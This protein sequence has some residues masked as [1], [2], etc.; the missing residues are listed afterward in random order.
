VQQQVRGRGLTL[1]PQRARRPHSGLIAI[2]ILVIL[3]LI[4]AGTGWWF[5]AGRWTEAPSLLKLSQQQATAK[6]AEQGLEVKLGQAR[7]S[8]VVPQGQVILQDPAPND[9]VR[10]GGVITLILS[11]GPERI[12]VPGVAGLQQSEAEAALTEKNLKFTVKPTFDPSVVNGTAVGTEPKEGTALAPGTVV[13][14]LVS[15]GAKPVDLR[16]LRGLSRAEAVQILTGLGLVPDISERNTDEEDERGRVL[17]Q[18]P[19]PG[20]IQAGSKV[21][22]TVGSGDAR[23]TVP[24]LSGM[25]FNEARKELQ[26]VGLEIRRVGKGNEVLFQLPVAGSEADAGSRVSVWFTR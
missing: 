15:Q 12:P 1:P 19:G 9:R 18:D 26:K 6:A 16:D 22:L 23:V 14:L 13:T 8:E 2:V 25:S 5:G 4:A 20:Q 21:K 7:H 10:E 24:D 11:L 17:E 3:G